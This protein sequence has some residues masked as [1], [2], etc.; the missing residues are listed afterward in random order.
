MKRL[1][2]FYLLL[3]YAFTAFS[4]SDN[5]LFYESKPLDSTYYK[6]LHLKIDA[7]GYFKNNEYFGPIESGYTLFG[8]QFLP[9]VTYYPSPNLLIEGGLFL[10]KE[11]GEDDFTKIRPIFSLKYKK[12]YFSM[13][14]GNLEGGLGHKLLEPVYDFE[15]GIQNRLESGLQFKYDHPR[16]YMDLWVDWRNSIFKGSTE[17]EEISS[18][19][20]TSYSLVHTDKF[21]FRPVLQGNFYHKGG[22]VNQSSAEVATVMNFAAGLRFN[23]SFGEGIVKSLQLDGYLLSYST[24]SESADPSE[25]EALYTNAY[26]KGKWL[27]VMVSYW[28]SENYLSPIGGGLYTSNS[29]VPETPQLIQ[30]N[31]ELL[32]VRLFKPFKLGQDLKAEVRFEPYYDFNNELFEYSFGFYLRMPLDFTLGKLK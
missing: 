18:G 24:D 23:F 4:Q 21:Q 28:S 10:Q 22:Q 16:W 14:F 9:K 11:F 12:K 17:Q 1:F 31:R 8:Y 3:F 32:F 7:F 20:Y 13:I 2:L 26:L 25:G 27:D 15:R 30:P 29:K 6:E 19:L 5:S